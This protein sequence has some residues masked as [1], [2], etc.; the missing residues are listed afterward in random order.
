MEE[1]IFQIGLLEDEAIELDT[2]A[3]QLA[4]LDHPDVSLSPYLGILRSILES[5]ADAADDATTPAGQADLLASV[6][7]GDYGF[8]GDRRDYDNPANADLIR[9]IDR[10]RGLPVS[11]GII[12]VAAARR[13]GWEAD[14]LGTPGH[15]LVRIGTVTE[16]V[17]I[18]VFDGGAK[19]EA[20]RL[21]GLLRRV[22]GP[23]VT[24]APEHLA[25]MPNRAILARL[26]VN[27]AM[28][29]E[30][31]G[32][33]ERALTVYER[34][35]LISPTLPHGWWERARLEMAKGDVPAAKHSLSA[36]LEITR[37]PDLRMHISSTLDSLGGTDG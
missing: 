5:I 18:D 3:L 26:L 23:G 8:A 24:P 29:A 7:A 21:G 2:S 37:D 17:L 13:L 32:D 28:R 16:P 22:L 31:A 20:G 14:I 34:M 9:V 36:M 10:R 11:L 27:Q 12:Y 1:T 25:P 30:S 15:V 35:T 4:A 19:V 33:R 6:I